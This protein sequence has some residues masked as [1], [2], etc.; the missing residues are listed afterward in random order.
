LLAAVAAPGTQHITGKTLGVDTYQYL[1]YLGHIA[2][3]K[4]QVF[5]FIESIGVAAELKIAVFSGHA[6]TGHS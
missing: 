6:S 1:I 2:H 3:V 4:S 5:L